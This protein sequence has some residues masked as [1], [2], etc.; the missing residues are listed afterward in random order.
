MSRLRSLE[1]SNRV[2]LAGSVNFP[3]AVTATLAADLKPRD[4]DSRPL[5]FDASGSGSLGKPGSFSH[6]HAAP[7]AGGCTAPTSRWR[8]YCCAGN[9]SRPLPWWPT[10]SADRPAVPRQA[11]APSKLSRITSIGVAVL[12]GCRSSPRAGVRGGFRARRSR[13]IRPC[14]PSAAVRGVREPATT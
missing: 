10:V 2:T 13:R 4:E 12:L 14:G 6:R 8:S 3:D 5:R 11:S 9:G 1:R 7:R